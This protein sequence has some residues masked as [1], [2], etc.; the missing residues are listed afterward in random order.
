M[1]IEV[2]GGIECTRNRVGDIY[3]DQIE[4]CGHLG[5]TDDLRLFSELGIRR[6]RYPALWEWVEKEPGERDWR[7]VDLTLNELRRLQLQPIIGLLHH[8]SGPRFTNLLDD[9][10]PERFADYARDFAKRYTWVTDYTP[11]N[12]PLTTARF[13]GLYGV[14]YPHQRN[15]CSFLKCLINQVHATQLAMQA[16][17][18]IQPKARLIHTEDL[19][20]AQ[21]TEPLQEQCDF[22]NQRRWLSCDLMLGR[23]TDHHPLAGYLNRSGLP[24]SDL[25]K[26]R[27]NAVLPDI[28]GWN[29]Y[30]LS[31]RYLD[32]RLERYPK[33]F[34]GGNGSQSYADVGAID[35]PGLTTVSVKDLLKEAWDQYQLPIALT[36]VHVRGHRESQI[37]WL[38]QLWTGCMEARNVGVD[39]RAITVWSLLGSYDWN[40]LCTKKEGFYEPGVFDLSNPL[41]R[42]RPTALARVVRNLACA[43]A[44]AEP[45]CR[46]SKSCRLLIIGRRGTLGKAFGRICEKR[47]LSHLLVG[48]DEVDI[49]NPDQV[50]KMIEEVNPWAVINTAGY[51]KLDGAETERELCFRENVT[52]AVVLADACARRD[53]P[54]LSYSSDQVFNGETQDP[55]CEKGVVDPLNHYGVC[56]AQAEKYILGTVAK[57]LIV[58]SSSYFGPWDEFNFLIRTLRDL[59]Q[60]KVVL[61]PN[62]IRI[63]PTYVPDLVNASLDLL[64]DGAQ[65]VF[66]LANRGNVSWAEFAQMALNYSGSA[67]KNRTRNLKGVRFEDLKWPA[68]RPKQ[69][70]LVSGRVSMLESLENAVERFFAD[71]PSRAGLA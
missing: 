24:E 47:S 41:Q 17:W 38:N 25:E 65:G 7:K 13:S 66:H 63:S 64:I 45:V 68:R 40:S 27:A 50:K 10:F 58:R 53:L 61:A 30:P 44:L 23:V 29:H 20:K 55:Y 56:K 14:W 6:L 28:L 32:H 15:D 1:K 22:E 8:G 2:W 33:I 34:H 48:R 59:K 21:A 37:R 57:S 51:V 19:G 5:R 12:E 42:P 35:V 69:S 36:E 52:G 39:V 71:L 67:L 3:F 16:I 54:L 49:A 18:S 9:D 31:N 26:V 43:G 46:S 11:V 60:D 4:R 62:D 70:V